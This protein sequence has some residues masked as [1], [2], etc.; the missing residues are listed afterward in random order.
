MV[1]LSWWEKL[2]QRMFLRRADQKELSHLVVPANE[3]HLP[4]EG[5]V[6]PYQPIMLDDWDGDSRE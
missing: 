3:N 5:C 2:L 1:V 4:P 6:Q